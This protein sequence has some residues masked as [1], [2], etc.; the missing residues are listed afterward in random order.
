M[1]KPLMI[2]PEDDKRIEA[3]KGKLG[4]KTKVDVVRA[5]LTLLEAETEK[6]ERIKRWI[7]AAKLVAKESAEVNEEFRHASLLKKI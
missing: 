5:G 1:G 3:L 7:K 6:H 4:T 2:Q